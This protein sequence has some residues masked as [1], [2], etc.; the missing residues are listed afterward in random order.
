M[1]KHCETWKLRSDVY[2]MLPLLS[3]CCYRQESRIF[4]NVRS[5][6][7]LLFPPPSSR[8][9]RSDFPPHNAVM[10]LPPGRSGSQGSD[11]ALLRCAAAEGRLCAPPPVWGASVCLH[12]SVL[13]CVSFD[14]R[15][16]IR[17]RAYT[18]SNIYIH[19]YIHTHTCTHTHIHTYTRWHRDKGVKRKTSTSRVHFSDTRVGEVSVVKVAL[20]NRSVSVPCTPWVCQRVCPPCL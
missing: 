9:N 15:F 8:S 13:V 3:V 16:L 4:S 2:T 5:T 11:D 6:C 18:H 20:C 7:F 10:R 14:T 19:T 17:V 1:L 12:V